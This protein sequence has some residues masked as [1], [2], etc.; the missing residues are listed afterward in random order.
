MKFRKWATVA[1]LACSAMTA[2]STAKAAIVADIMWVI[3]ISGSMGG[4]IAQV[5]QRIAE[6]NTVMVNNSIDAQFGLVSFG[7][8]PQLRQDLTDFN[9]FTAAGS[10]FTVLT[11]NGGAT[12]DGSLALQTAMTATFRAN[13]VRNFIMVTDEDDDNAGN[14]PAL[15]AAL[16]ATPENELINIIAQPGAGQDYYEPLATNNGGLFFDILAFRANPQPFFTSFINT[17]VNEIIVDF[18]TRNPNDPSCVVTDV[19]EPGSLAL[20]GLALLGVASTRR[21]SLRAA[22]MA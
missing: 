3:D 17:K 15:Q 11:A 7:G 2:V 13:S 16:D 22:H 19:P 9:T 8:A 4:D 12:E 10:A 21:R 20:V 14:R 18:C 1:A 5:K 6:F